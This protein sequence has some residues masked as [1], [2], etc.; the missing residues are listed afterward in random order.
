MNAPGTKRASG[1]YPDPDDPIR[2]RHWSGRSWSGRRRPLPAW[3]V[4]FRQVTPDSSL[5]GGEGVDGPV[6]DGPVRAEALP[7]IAA[8]SA[9]TREMP[10]R[11][12]HPART[13]TGSGSAG[14]AG[15]ATLN[16]LPPSGLD[17]QRFVLLIVACVAVL[18][19]LIA[20]VNAG[21]SGAE[22]YSAVSIDR[23][24]LAA[25]NRA[26]SA[27]FGTGHPAPSI[28]SPSTTAGDAARI[29]AG[30]TSLAT[31]ETK[32]EA[33]PVTPAAADQVSRWLTDPRRAGRLGPAS[34]STG[35][36]PSRLPRGPTAS[37]CA[38]A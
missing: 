9:H 25:A 2:M 12:P 26:C 5:G 32:L 28:T 36:T 13:G 35:P 6:L 22:A 1:W 14:R 18:A 11:R 10:E 30:A 34:P 21:N 19:L 20:V 37:L 38:T 27:A 15:P 31:L 33:L 29:K 4:A 23:S 3:N 7:A 8:A 24:Y 17:R 16:L